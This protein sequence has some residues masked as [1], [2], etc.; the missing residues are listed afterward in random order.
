MWG[1]LPFWEQFPK[2]NE[3]RF[4]I[5]G[6]NAAVVGL[7]LS[8]FYNPVWTSAIRDS[9]DFSLAALGILLLAFWKAPSWFLVLVSALMAGLFL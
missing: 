6:I 9:K 2:H 4:A 3:V 1:V 5:Q 8:A 7:P